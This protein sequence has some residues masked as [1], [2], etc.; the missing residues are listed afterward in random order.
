MQ[1]QSFKSLREAKSKLKLRLYA[2]QQLHSVLYGD[3]WSH[4]YGDSGVTLGYQHHEVATPDDDP[5]GRIDD[6]TFSNLR[7]S[8]CGAQPGSIILTESN[9][10]SPKPFVLSST[11][12]GEVNTFGKPRNEDR[13]SHLGEACR[14]F[15][16]LVGESLFG[17]RKLVG[18]ATLNFSAL[19]MYFDTQV[20]GTGEGHVY[21]GVLKSVKNSCWSPTTSD[22]SCESDLTRNYRLGAAVALPPSLFGLLANYQPVLSRS[23]VGS[24]PQTERIMEARGETYARKDAWGMPI[25]NTRGT[26][27]PCRAPG[28]AG[29]PTSARRYKNRIVKETVGKEKH[30]GNFNWE[31]G[32]KLSCT[33]T[34]IV[35]LLPRETI[36]HSSNT[37]RFGELA[38]SAV[39]NIDFPS[40]SSS[41][42]V[43]GSFLTNLLYRVDCDLN[44]TAGNGEPSKPIRISVGD[45]GP[46]G[47]NKWGMNIKRPREGIAAHGHLNEDKMVGRSC[48]K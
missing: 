5:E 7:S 32:Y 6:A 10:S 4:C 41:A 38:S 40:E 9:P 15:L 8:G 35:S 48:K 16:G 1:V 34:S 22:W 23:S 21:M 25:E 18:I 14:H 36:L 31:D 2:E 11:H 29:V 43:M 24:G 19:G 17:P 3:G 27:E 47:T 30:P 37:V 12:P 20:S 13:N 39:D 42:D 33:W 26:E 46:R 44:P 45:S 28:H